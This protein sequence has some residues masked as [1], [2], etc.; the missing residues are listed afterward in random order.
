MWLP[1]TTS[2]VTITLVGFSPNSNRRHKTQTSKE[3][4]SNQQ[5]CAYGR[6]ARGRQHERLKDARLQPQPT[7]RHGQQT[8]VVFFDTRKKW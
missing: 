6:S 4:H 8:N 2:F 5:W 7:D 1:L 3:V